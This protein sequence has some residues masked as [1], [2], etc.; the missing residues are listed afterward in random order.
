MPFTYMQIF[1]N[2]INEFKTY[3][4]NSLKREIGREEE[5]EEKKKRRKKKEGRGN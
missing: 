1:L 5:D 4:V 2:R 3:T